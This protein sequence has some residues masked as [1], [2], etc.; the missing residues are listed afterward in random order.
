M[1]AGQFREYLKFMGPNDDG[2]DACCFHPILPVLA[3]RHLKNVAFFTATCGS[4]PFSKWVDSKD[5]Y[6]C[7]QNITVLAWNVSS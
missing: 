1:N 7:L 4:A 6:E 3:F 5:R 2:C